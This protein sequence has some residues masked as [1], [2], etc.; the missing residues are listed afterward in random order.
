VG[1]FY[2]IVDPGTSGL[3]PDLYKGRFVCS[4]PKGRNRGKGQSWGWVW[5]SGSAAGTNVN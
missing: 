2:D 4:K 3:E 1:R 5:G